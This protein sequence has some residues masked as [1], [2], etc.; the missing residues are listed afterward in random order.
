M[1]RAITT[2]CYSTTNREYYA[3]YLDRLRTSLEQYAKEYAFLPWRTEW[4]PGSPAHL[5]YP[6]AFKYYAVK[7]G[8][9]RGYRY[10]MWLDAGTQ[11]IAPIEPLWDRIKSHGYALLNGGDPLGKWI[12]DYA[13]EKYSYTREK[14][15]SMT[16]AGG[17]LV[18][19]D[20]ESDRAMEFFKHWGYLVQDKK[21]LMG[22][23][24]RSKE[25]NG[26][27]R[28]LMLSDA[29]QSPISTDP[30]VEGHR[31]DESC[32][33]LLMDRLG[34]EPITYTEWQKVCRTY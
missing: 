27:M 30:T 22:A 13:L 3:S 21:L 6:Y 31:S 23:N 33:S 1:S 17:C 29:D 4:P 20:R 19:L 26:V 25:D 7:D 10:V 11:A 16:L 14:A 28:S 24:R 5:E 12:S 9:D 8:F 18:G 32:F 34:M 15:N 2:C